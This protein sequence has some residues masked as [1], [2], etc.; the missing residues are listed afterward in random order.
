MEPDLNGR[1]RFEIQPNTR[2]PRVWAVTAVTKS[3]LNNKGE[4]LAQTVTLPAGGGLVLVYLDRIGARNFEGA[5][6]HE[7]GHVL[8]LQHE[9]TQGLMSATYNPHDQ[10]CVDYAAAAQIARLY[11]LPIQE[12]KWCGEPASR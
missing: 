2:A 4:S 7:L 3:P 1:I 6:L 12:L 8:G 9:G 10:K 11:N 5:L